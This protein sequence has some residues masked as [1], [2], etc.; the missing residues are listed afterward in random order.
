MGV[1][2]GKGEGGRENKEREGVT[3]Y[4]KDQVNKGDPGL[5]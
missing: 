4:Q 1:G 3:C 2:D 5:A